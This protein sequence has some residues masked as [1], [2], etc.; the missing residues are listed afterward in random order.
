MVKKEKKEINE[1]NKIFF[2]YF[3]IFYYVFPNRPETNWTRSG[4]RVGKKI[5]TTKT[6]F[7]CFVS[8][9]PAGPRKPAGNRPEPKIKIKNPKIINN[10]FLIF[11]YFCSGIIFKLQWKPPI[12]SRLAHAKGW[13]G[14]AP[15]LL[16]VYPNLVIAS[17]WMA[18]AKN[19]R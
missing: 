5:K 8:E 6:W 18:T 13:G 19:G 2:I 4:R 1:I 3:Y 9:K 15:V 16:R 14:Y 11:L 17:F 7:F 12:D 10:S